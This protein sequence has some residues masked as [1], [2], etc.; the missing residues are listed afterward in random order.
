MLP[1]AVRLRTPIEFSK[2][3]AI[4]RSDVFGFLNRVSCV[5]TRGAAAALLIVR[6]ESHRLSVGEL[7]SSI[8]RLR[9]TGCFY[10][11]R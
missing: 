4:Y 8:A 2:A 6:D 1:G 11:M 9:F 3:W 7:L 5:K 10:A